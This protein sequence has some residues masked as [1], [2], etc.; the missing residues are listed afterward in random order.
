MPTYTP[1]T[2]Q[3]PT[4][5]TPGQ[6]GVGVMALQMQLNKQNANNPSYVPLKEDG[7][8]GPKTQAAANPNNLVTT[9][10]SA[11]ADMMKNSTELNNFLANFN[12]GGT[13]A[14]TS[15]N[16]ATPTATT[17]PNL[18]I[19]DRMSA[20]S[21]QATKSMIATIQANKARQE[22]ALNKQYE[23]YKGGLQLLGIQ[24]N[25]AQSSP[26]LLRGHIQQAENQ[27]L[28]KLHEIEATTSKTLMDAK[29]AQLNNDYKTLQ[30]KNTYLKQLQKEKQTTLKNYYD[31]M[32]QQPKIAGEVAHSI[33]N[34]IM[35]LGDEDKQAAIQAIAKQ[36]NLPLGTLVTAL[37]DEHGKSQLQTAKIT[38]AI[39][40]KSTTAKTSSGK[41]STAQV[42]AAQN[43]LDKQ[44]TSEG[45]LDPA[46]YN[47]ALKDWTDKGESVKDFIKNFPVDGKG[48]YIRPESYQYLPESIRPKASTN[49]GRG[50]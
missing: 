26:E 38:K 12:V 41:I 17:D 7:L 28:D 44:R 30:E 19:L 4:K 14:P 48:G 33:Y 2:N 18:A 21:D 43:E 35:K 34:E 25:E 37:S 32:T 11:R 27:H 36:F 10:S 8:Y 49:S 46:I 20:N 47:Q 45:W 29:T 13:N 24:H 5:A 1:S 15:E 9:S 16:G 6:S 50:L 42:T 23:D 3:D 40:P 39:T 31:S 22:N